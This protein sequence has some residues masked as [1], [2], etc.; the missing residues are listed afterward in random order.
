MNIS[1]FRW[2]QDL[3]YCKYTEI[4]LHDIKISV[5]LVNYNYNQIP[6]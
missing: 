6:F 3:E 5:V 1:L 4:M 2:L